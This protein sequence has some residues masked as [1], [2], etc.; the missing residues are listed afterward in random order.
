MIIKYIINIQIIFFLIFITGCNDNIQN[1]KF[2]DQN[3]FEYKIK[4]NKKIEILLFPNKNNSIKCQVKENNITYD[5]K[6]NTLIINPIDY[7][8]SEIIKFQIICNS[9]TDTRYYKI[10]LIIEDILEINEKINIDSDYKYFNEKQFTYEI[11]H[12]L[13]EKIWSIKKIKEN[14]FVTIQSGKIVLLDKKF[15]IVKS[16]DLNEYLDIYN[17]GQGGLLDIEFSNLREK[18][19]FTY[20]RLTD[21]YNSKLVLASIH[22]KSIEDLENPIIEI[23]DEYDNSIFSGHYGG[24]LEIQDDKLFLTHGERGKNLEVQ[25]ENTFGRV[26]VYTL[27]NNERVEFAKGI[28]NSQGITYIEDLQTILFTDHGPK[29]GDEINIL[30]VDENYGWPI[31]TKGVSYSNDEKI[32]EWSLSGYKEPYYY[33]IP[34]IAPRAI[35]STKSISNPSNKVIYVSSLKFNQILEI[36]IDKDKN[37]KTRYTFPFDIRIGSVIGNFNDDSGK[38]ELIIVSHDSNGYIIKIYE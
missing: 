4:E 8:E 1:V 28:R 11:L 16:I 15:Q 29:G 35:I 22:Y 31:V 24:A 10:D 14:F 23:I 13:R 7:E 26:F 17:D 19:Y 9:K 5:N 30:N 25:E 38:N 18:I 21:Q 12:T 3:I 37:N 2:P 27:S 6:K 33:F 32:G 20:T 36:D 34:S